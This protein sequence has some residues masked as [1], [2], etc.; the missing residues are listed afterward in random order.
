[1]KLRGLV[2]NFYIHVCMSDLYIPTIG[3]QTQYSKISGGLIVG[4]CKSLTYSM[5]TYMNVENGNEAAQFHFWKY[6]FRIFG[7][8]GAFSL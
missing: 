1:M 3:P 2:P 7:T 4:I 5:Y 6:L 8:V